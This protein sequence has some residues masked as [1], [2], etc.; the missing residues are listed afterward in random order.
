MSDYRVLD[1]LAAELGEF[2]GTRTVEQTRQEMAQLGPWAG[3]RAAMAPVTGI[4]QMPSP[5]EGEAVLATWPHLLD[6]GLMQ[7]GEPFLAGTAPTPVARIS[8]TTAK[9]LGLSEGEV[10]RVSTGTGSIAL[11]AAVTTMPDHVVWLPTNSPGSAVRATLRAGAGD[12]VRLSK[13]GA[14]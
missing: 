3:E 6:S 5:G 11:P 2:L 10:L 9:E 13:G 4:P 12:L 14:A 8:A 7:A 1:L